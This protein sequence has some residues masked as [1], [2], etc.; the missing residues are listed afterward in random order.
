MEKIGKVAVVGIL[1]EGDGF[2]EEVLLPGAPLNATVMREPL[3]RARSLAQAGVGLLGVC[4]EDEFRHG[5]VKGSLNLPPYLLRLKTFGLDSK[6][7]YVVFCQTGSR[8]YSALFL[9]S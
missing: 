6:R 4:T 5:T 3:D 1:G 8:N 7:H 2:G 9:P